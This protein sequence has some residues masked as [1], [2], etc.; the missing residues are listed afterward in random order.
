M[1]DLKLLEDLPAAVEPPDDLTKQRIKSRMTDRAGRPS[2]HFQPKRKVAVLCAALV[3][4]GVASAAAAVVHPWTPNHPIAVPSGSQQPGYFTPDIPNP[5]AYLTTPDQIQSAAAE[6]EGSIRLPDGGS[7]DE[8]TR[9][10]ITDHN[11]TLPGAGYTRVEVVQYMVNASTCQWTQQWIKATRNGQQP[12][13]AEAARVLSD[14]NDWATATGYQAMTNALTAVT[15]TDTSAATKFE[16]SQCA[17]T[18]SW[19]ASSSVQDARANATLDPAIEIAQHFLR[20]GR[21]PRSFTWQTAEALDSNVVWASEETSPSPFPGVVFIAQPT[22]PGITLV[23]VSETG[24][25]FCTV[26]TPT[27]VNRGTTTNDIRTAIWTSGGLTET[28]PEPVTCST[29]P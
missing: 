6:F 28:T 22:A 20:Q 29:R 25:Q 18:G 5:D 2:R 19:G 13:A 16:N 15:A 17:Y 11:L 27:E 3:V 10:A 24:E 12:L 7:F 21:D 23:S 14:M 1:N 8:W 26:I 4:G 9:H